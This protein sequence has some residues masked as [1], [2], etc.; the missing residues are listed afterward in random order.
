MAART[1]VAY[2][3]MEERLIRNS[4]L[5][6]VTECWDW[7]GA[8]DKRASTP[9]GKMTVYDEE[10]GRRVRQAHL[11][12]Y[13]TFIG[14]IP[15]GHEIDHTCRNSYCIAPYHLEPV[16]PAVNKQRRKFKHTARSDA[17]VG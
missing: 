6:P 1:G 16:L 5:D 8:R 3:D 13:E 9:Y 11:V 12:S 2:R 17:Y 14:P 10:G 15:D 7:I 4:V